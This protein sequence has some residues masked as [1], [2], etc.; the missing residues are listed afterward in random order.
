MKDYQ[1]VTYIEVSYIPLFADP[2][3]SNTIGVVVVII[4]LLCIPLR[5][6]PNMNHRPQPLEKVG[7][8]GKVVRIETPFEYECFRPCSIN[9]YTS[10]HGLVSG[11]LQIAYIVRS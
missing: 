5:S 8:M 11:G 9:Y 1:I 7:V 10:L 6:R 4:V 2:G 3:K